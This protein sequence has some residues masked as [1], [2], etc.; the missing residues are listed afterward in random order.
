[1][2]IFFQYKFLPPG[3]CIG[4]RTNWHVK[5]FQWTVSRKVPYIAGCLLYLENVQYILYS[6]CINYLKCGLIF[7]KLGCSL[8]SWKY[9]YGSLE[10]VSK[11]VSLKQTVSDA[12]RVVIQVLNF[13]VTRQNSGPPPLPAAAMYGC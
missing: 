4:A 10:R 11:E 13:C 7:K 5:E 2:R 1:M 3:H 12:G 9:E 6:P 8:I